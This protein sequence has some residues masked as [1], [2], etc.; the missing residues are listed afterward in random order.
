[1]LVCVSIT[2]LGRPELGWVRGVLEER[3]LIKKM[4]NGAVKREG[5]H[6]NI[7]CKNSP[8]V[9]DE[10]DKN[11]TSSFGLIPLGSS[12]SRCVKMAS[13]GL[14]PSTSFPPNNKI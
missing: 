14:N 9:P 8:V 10:Y 6:K 1:M 12:I 13:K 7:A 4:A 5:I 2:P 11:A 3:V